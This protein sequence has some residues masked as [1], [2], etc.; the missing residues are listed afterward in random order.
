MAPAVSIIVSGFGLREASWDRLRSCLEAIARQDA[1]L[2]EVLLVEMA[3]L[4]GEVSE[5]VRE[6]LPSLKSVP[7]TSSDPWARKTAGV[8]NA[9]TPIVAFV[10]ADCM[11]QAGWLQLIVETFQY[12]PEVAV[13]RGAQEAT[14]L[15]R[16]LPGWRG[17]GPVSTTATHNVAF[18]REAYLD[19]PFP[20]GSGSQAV[21]L[22]SVALRRAGYLLWSEPAIRVNR[23]RCLTPIS[24]GRHLLTSRFARL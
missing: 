21:A 3:G 13:I 20:P 19:C 9:T 10:D 1:G 12:Y 7:C 23:D 18:R 17:A 5:D 16:L 6:V 15:R 24:T 14:W 8:Q 11:P 2:V 22:Q 4:Q